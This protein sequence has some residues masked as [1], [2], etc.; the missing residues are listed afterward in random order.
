MEFYTRRRWRFFFWLHSWWGVGRLSR[1][2]RTRQL[3]RVTLDGLFVY[4]CEEWVSGW[5]GGASK[6][7]SEVF[8]RWYFICIPNEI[9]HPAASSTS[10]RHQVLSFCSAN[11]YAI[12]VHAGVYLNVCV[13][14]YTRYDWWRQQRWLWRCWQSNWSGG[15][16]ER[17]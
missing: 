16:S 3:F 10:H 1:S 15:V 5:L 8:Y 13:G 6:W 11:I 9:E 17:V 4:G 14:V 2:E 12:N 7:V